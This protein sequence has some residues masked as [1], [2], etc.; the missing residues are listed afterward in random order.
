MP[1]ST[2]L[3]ALIVE[4]AADALIYCDAAGIIRRWN[5][6]A[7]RLFGYGADEA[8]GQSLDLIIP[9]HLRAAHWRGFNAAVSK[10][11]VRS[12]GRLG[13]TRA[14]GRGG[15]KL[16]AEISFAMVID[17]SGEVL[18]S[19]AMARQVAMPERTGT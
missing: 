4:Q 18:G 8:L 17:A 11:S 19:V 13:V 9:E 10:G 7:E 16:Y 1:E 14:L 2:S 3:D 6:A 12:L 15:C 5:H